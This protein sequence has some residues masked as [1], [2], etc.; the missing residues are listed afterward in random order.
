MFVPQDVRHRGTRSDAGPEPR[1]ARSPRSR[2]STPPSCL[3]IT[4]VGNALFGLLLF[5]DPVITHRG[6]GGRLPRC[7]ASAPPD[8]DGTLAVGAAEASLGARSS[9]SVSAPTH[10]RRGPAG[11]A[12]RAPPR[13]TRLG[14][15][16][17]THGAN[18]HSAEAFGPACVTAVAAAPGHRGRPVIS[19]PTASTRNAGEPL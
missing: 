4:T 15:A 17:T 10:R 1:W 9:T 2:A 19:P 11:S 8:A 7:R 3:P 6:V 5:I 16:P 14:S 18:L 13:L 12:R